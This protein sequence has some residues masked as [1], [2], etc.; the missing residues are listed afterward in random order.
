M[1]STPYEISNK[2]LICLDGTTV[3][4]PLLLT[5]PAMRI[6]LFFLCLTYQ[7]IQYLRTVFILY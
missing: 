4:K 2:N 7:V 3:S 6:I 5:R 1:C